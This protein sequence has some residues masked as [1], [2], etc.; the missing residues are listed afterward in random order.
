LPSADAPADFREPLI[1]AAQFR[2]E[3]AALTKRAERTREDAVRQAYADLARRWLM[4]A[5]QLE[6][7]AIAASQAVDREPTDDDD[8]RDFDAGLQCRSGQSAETLIV[9]V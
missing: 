1:R 5:A 9:N 6:S 4:F 2:A 8:G 3:A 7:D